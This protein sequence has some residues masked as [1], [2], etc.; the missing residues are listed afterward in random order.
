MRAMIDT[1]I[2][3]SAILSRGTPFEAYKKAVTFPNRGVVCTQNIEELQ[4]IFRQKFPTRLRDLE[5]F[6]SLAIPSLE[7]IEVPDIPMEEE[8]AVRDV[9]DRPILRAAIHEKVD[10]L[11]TGDKDFLESGIV[12]PR[13]MTAA[14]FVS[15]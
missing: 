3:I 11:I 14:E 13:I 2:L 15:I 1:N 5:I 6:L 10:V 7:V 8:N 4:R 9:H 12:M